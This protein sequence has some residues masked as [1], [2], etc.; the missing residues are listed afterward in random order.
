M[1]REQK[2]A[3]MWGYQQAYCEGYDAGYERGFE[4]GYSK[5]FDKGRNIGKVTMGFLRVDCGC[6]FVV[7]LPIL[8]TKFTIEFQIPDGERQRCS[9]CGNLIPKKAFIR[10]FTKQRKLF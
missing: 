7:L 2:E 6:G 9:S 3:W 10:A 8:K 1:N 4:E 5:G